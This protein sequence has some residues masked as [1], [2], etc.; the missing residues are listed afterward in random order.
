MRE[1]A[2]SL[3]EINKKNILKVIINRSPISRAE[4]SR[5]L[6]T[7]RPT[8]S[9]Y[10]N[11]LIEDNMIK[12]VGK[13]ESS[14]LGG[15]RATLLEFNSRAGYILGI[16]IG[17]KTIRIAVTDLLSNVVE[18]IKVPTEEWLGTEAVINKIVRGSKEIIKK[19]QFDKQNIIGIGIGVPG[20]VYSKEGTVIFS[21]NL[22]G[23][24]NINL[25]EIVEE[26]IG[27]PTF[28]ENECWVQARAEKLYGLAK[29]SK[30]F[31]CIETGVGIGSG[32]FINDRLLVGNKG[33][34]GEI[35]HVTTNLGGNKPCHCGNVGCLETLCSVITLTE[36][37]NKDIQN[38]SKLVIKGKGE[39]SLTDLYKLYR[40]DNKIVAMRVEE[41]A[42]YLGIGISNAIKIFN[43]EIVIIHGEVIKFGEKYLNIVR[44]SVT[45]NTFPKVKDFYNI[46]FSKLGEN[47]GLIGATSIVF[48][49]IFNLDSLNV[50]DEYLVKKIL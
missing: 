8:I 45:K 31:F 4:V 23:W 13:S 11:D 49:N 26:K 29:G 12:E 37:V 22:T 42:R 21:P 15:K 50:T 7:S 32:V 34:A 24:T 5:L 36:N 48:E 35:G 46:Q 10:I 38:S 17:V 40:E 28:I 1:K 27:L 2:I 16:M 9:A 6:R 18:I 47:V 33:M 44:E 25:K 19:V 20:L 43:P 30:N 41:N 39:V 14:S 3:K